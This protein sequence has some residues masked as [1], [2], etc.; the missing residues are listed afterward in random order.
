[1]AQATGGTTVLSAAGVV[2]KAGFGETGSLLQKVIDATKGITPTT[3]PSG[4]S[5]LPAAPTGTGPFELVIPADYTGSL[6]IPTGYTYVVYTGSGQLT[7]GDAGTVIV[8]TNLSY[9]GG[10][11]TVLG[12]GAGTVTDTN[13]SAVLSFSSIPGSSTSSAYTV[14]TTGTGDK[15]Y[16]DNGTTAD[17]FAKGSA[18]DVI[19]G[20]LGSEGDGS[21]ASGPV[22]AATGSSATPSFI[23][24]NPSSTGSADTMQAVAGNTFAFAFADADI[25]GLGGNVTVIGVPTTAGGAPGVVTLNATPSLGGTQIV[26]SGGGNDLIN[27]GDNT[28]YVS[29]A[30]GQA[31][32]N[33]TAG[34]ADTIF[35]LSSI[36]YT[37]GAANSLFFLAETGAV[38]VAAAGSETL[39][40]GSGGGSYSIGATSFTYDAGALGLGGADTF[41]GAAGSASVGFFG[42]SGENLTVDQA[43]GTKGNTFI[44]FGENETINATNTSGKDV[45]QIFNTS[46]NPSATTPAAS[47]TGDTTLIGSSAGGEI[48]AL[49]VDT[50]A[51]TPHTIT[52][53]NWQSSDVIVVSNFDN[54]GGVQGALSTADAAAVTAFNAGGSSTL[55]LSDGTTIKFTGSPTVFIH[56]S[57]QA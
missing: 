15:V 55:S 4:A 30:T 51:T 36:D 34:G 24:L 6:N 16:V 12:T 56:D 3:V 13:N 2:V 41:T 7:G 53:S 35:A 43:A 25:L 18:S 5:S 44:T 19:V 27:A 14:N 17:V 57:N 1:M 28:E 45:F 48:F 52:I 23:S 54:I 49:S 26:F 32:Y 40:G 20:T 38:T 22:L 46:T 42:A 33:A 11:G 21:G 50:T 29:A 47:F 9:S 39:F 10:A 37:G 31:T 8:G